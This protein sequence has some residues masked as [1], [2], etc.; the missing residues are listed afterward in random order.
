MRVLRLA[1]CLFGGGDS[2]I[3]VSAQ[4][5]LRLA[6]LRAI[7]TVLCLGLLVMFPPSLA[8]TAVSWSFDG[9]STISRCHCLQWLLSH[10]LLLPLLHLPTLRLATRPS[11]PTRNSWFSGKPPTKRPAEFLAPSAFAAFFGCIVGFLA[12]LRG[13]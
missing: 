3:S 11:P 12:V 2:G 6:C 1:R 10:S 9:V 7:P 8:T 4:P 13:D 5:I